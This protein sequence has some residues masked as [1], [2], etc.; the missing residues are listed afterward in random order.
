MEGFDTTGIVTKKEQVVL[1][2][3][4][5]DDD[6]LIRS[7]CMY[8]CPRTDH[9]VIRCSGALYYWCSRDMTGHLIERYKELKR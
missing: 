2:P 9:E 5:V 8:Q 7:V 4:P 3:E 1:C 6:A